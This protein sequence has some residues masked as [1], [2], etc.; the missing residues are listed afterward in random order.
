LN[1][2]FMQ[3]YNWP[4]GNFNF[5]DMF[6]NPDAEHPGRFRSPSLD[7]YSSTVAKTLYG[8]NVARFVIWV[9][10]G[11]YASLYRAGPDLPTSQAAPQRRGWHRE[12]SYWSCG[13]GD[14]HGEYRY[15]D[16]RSV[17]G[18]NITFWDPKVPF[19]GLPR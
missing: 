3:G 19:G 18:E 2:R 5:S 13:F 7:L 9:E 11:C 8:G 16:T 10:Q 17:N 14:G 12:Y 1:T 15:V 4:P 6:G